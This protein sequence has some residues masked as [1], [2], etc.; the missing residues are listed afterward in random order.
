MSKRAT[1]WYSRSVFP[2][3]ERT[4]E[5]NWLVTIWWFFTFRARKK[6][7]KAFQCFSAAEYQLHYLLAERIQYG[8]IINNKETRIKSLE[9]GEERQQMI[10]HFNV[11]EAQII[12]EGLN[13]KNEP[14]IPEYMGF[15]TIGEKKTIAYEREGITLAPIEEDKW[16]VGWLETTNKKGEEDEEME[17]VWRF[18]TV[19]FRHMYDAVAFLRPMGLEIE[20]LQV[21]DKENEGEAELKKLFAAAEK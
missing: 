8:E 11:I 1:Q 14:V 5:I 10:D 21:G 2:V 16:S 9:S 3:E 12:E 6:L 17:Q 13:M 4:E 19:T 20:P 18:R 7:I 15:R